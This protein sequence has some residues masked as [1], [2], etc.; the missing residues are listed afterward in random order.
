MRRNP[1]VP[2]AMVGL[3]WLVLPPPAARAEPPAGFQLDGTRF[4]YKDD[5]LSFR[6]VLLTP[7]GKGPFPAVL[8]SH[9]QGGGP[10]GFGLPKAKEFVQWGLV[11]IAPE[12][13]HA[14]GG[15][16]RK[17]FG[18]SAENLR[19]AVKCLDIL[20]GLPTVDGKRLFAYGNSMG[21]FVT[22]G[23]AATAPDRLKAAAIT[24]GGVAPREG[25]P[26]PSHDLAAKVRTPFLILHGTADT[27]VRPEQSAVLKDILDKSTVPNERRLFEGVG[28]GLHNDKSAEVYRAIRA[29][30]DKHGKR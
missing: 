15:G 17:T 30:F 6:G 28:H 19:R 12:Y 11:C 2:A 27:T 9:G 18:A 25:F 5:Q 4:A 14:A 22:I 3:A 26:A 8:I 13:T 29:W 7:E 20:A 23:L 21:G 1:V 16:D 10:E 24:A